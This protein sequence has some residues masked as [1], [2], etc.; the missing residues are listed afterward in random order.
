M[1]DP[2]GI[3]PA[4][5][6]KAINKIRGLADFLLIGDL[7]VMQRQS[8]MSYQQTTLNF[9]DLNNVSRKNFS[10]GKVRAEYGKASIEYLD[11]AL[12]LLKN[13]EIDCLVTSPISKEAINKAGFSFPGHTEYLAKKTGCKKYAMMLINDRLKFVLATR[14]VAISEVHAQLNKDKI[15]ETASLAY[16]ALNKLFLISEPRI[17]VCGLNPHASDNGL[18]GNEENKIIKPAVK[19]LKNKFSGISGPIAA[20]AA[21]LGAYKQKYDCIIAMYHDQALI[22]LKLTGASRG[23]NLTIGL[24]FIRTSPLHGT[25]FDIAAKPG[26]AD[27]SSLVSSIKTAVSCA[28][29]QCR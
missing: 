25:A 26:L 19:N 28:Q 29:N 4:I 20:D 8:A 14:H 12:G 7:W 17:A 11:C 9:I 13:K 10:F 16:A 2:S 3:G 15:C 6:H 18:L 5:I 22:P 24:D 1:G 27:P 23:V 21:I